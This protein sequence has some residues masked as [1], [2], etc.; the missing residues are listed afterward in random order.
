[1]DPKKKS[2]R[3]I[4]I[5]SNFFIQMGQK[6]RNARNAKENLV[7]KIPIQFRNL[8]LAPRQKFMI[9]LCI[10]GVLI[11]KGLKSKIHS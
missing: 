1:M 7:D 10:S 6:Y 3:K 5:Y 9:L 4:P 11:F 2:F 8:K